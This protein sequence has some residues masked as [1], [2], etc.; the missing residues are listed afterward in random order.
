MMR[1][2]DM[3]IQSRTCQ[4]FAW[5]LALLPIGAMLTGCSPT[6][7]NSATTELGLSPE[8]ARDY[9]EPADQLSKNG[10]TNGKQ[11]TTVSMRMSD[12]P[13]PP[14]IQLTAANSPIPQADEQTNTTTNPTTQEMST[15]LATHAEPVTY[16]TV[17]HVDTSQFQQEVLDTDAPVLVDFYADWCGPCRR[18]APTLEKLARQ[19]PDA[20]IVK[21]NID[22]SPELAKRYQ[23]QSIPAVMVF[24]QGTVAA[25]KVGLAD[26][27]TLERMLGS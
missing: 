16:G 15:I 21:V 3:K 6:A 19:R 27:A 26:A 24:R 12:Q 8:A 25:R 2:R 5:T 17:L 9:G 22:H 23:I 11:K 13:A 4:R 18:L 20:K 7:K 14:A 1:E 10:D